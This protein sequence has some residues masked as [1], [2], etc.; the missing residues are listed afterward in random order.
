MDATNVR[1]DA[2]MVSENQGKVV[3]SV[4]KCKSASIDG[5]TAVLEANGEINLSFDD[6]HMEEG[7]IYEV[8]GKV[9]SSNVIQMYV[10][11]ELADDTNIELAS[12]LAKLASKVPEVFG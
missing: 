9:N 12:R 7:K 6:Q 4:G 3:R 10:A 2:S 11:V 1:V 5:N 8:M